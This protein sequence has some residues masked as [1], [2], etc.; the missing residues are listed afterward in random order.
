MFTRKHYLIVINNWVVG[1]GGHSGGSHK[2]GNERLRP[3][4]CIMILSQLSI[5]SY[6]VYCIWNL[7]VMSTTSV[8]MNFQQSF[9]YYY[10]QRIEVII[11]SFSL[12]LIIVFRVDYY[13]SALDEKVSQRSHV[14]HCESFLL[15]LKNF[16]QIY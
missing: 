8:L 3:L 2:K 15:R 5:A 6:L 1:A 9:D 10:F 4:N 16:S 12:I 11:K 13:M 7:C 14:Y